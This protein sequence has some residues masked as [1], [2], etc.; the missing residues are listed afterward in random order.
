MTQTWTW[1]ESP[2]AHKLQHAWR[3]IHRDTGGEIHGSACGLSLEGRV[4][5]DSS[6]PKCHSCL[7]KLRPYRSIPWEPT[8]DE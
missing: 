3:L 5:L 4:I 7:V 1:G 2:R 8:N 6:K